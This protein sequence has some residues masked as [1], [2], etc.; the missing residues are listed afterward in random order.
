M[1]H[2]ELIVALAM[3]AA[4]SPLSATSPQPSADPAPS[5]TP[6]TRYC[7]RVE[8]VIGSHIET[9]QCWTR[10]EWAA[11]E[12]NVDEEWAREGVAVIEGGVRQPKG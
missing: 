5:G 12:V 7:L 10:D 6:E 3:I 1:A 11:K 9:I 8:P 4:A 2:K